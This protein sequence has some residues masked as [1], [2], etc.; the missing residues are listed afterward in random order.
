[1]NNWE[2]NMKRI[3][4]SLLLVTAIISGCG[5][6]EDVTSVDDKAFQLNTQKSETQT[7]EVK[8]DNSK[9]TATTLLSKFIKE[10]N[11]GFT[12][13]V[14]VNE[15][16]N[17]TVDSV[18]GKSYDTLLAIKQ[19][20]SITMGKDKKVKMT[21]Y[22]GHSYTYNTNFA[23]VYGFVTS[24]KAVD[25]H[26]LINKK[27]KEYTQD[28]VLEN[29]K[30]ACYAIDSA[31]EKLDARKFN[32]NLV[33]SDFSNLNFSENS[34]GYTV[35]GTVH[36]KLFGTLFNF[37][38]IYTASKLDNSD[39]SYNVT[40]VF[41]KNKELK[42]L[43]MELVK[44]TGK[45]ESTLKRISDIYIKEHTIELKNIQFHVDTADFE[46]DGKADKDFY[47]QVNKF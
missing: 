30:N 39:C 8:E 4:V 29:D 23:D 27:A 10:L 35:K 38:D 15:N 47:V 40:F 46:L 36:S 45:Y 20:G 9:V 3:L 24:N 34:D 33:I 6:T 42:S 37:E 41:D 1:M 25:S 22:I 17:V 28:F 21:G 5:K 26:S 14:V 13:D 44:G 11:T 43:S 19:K 18:K 32:T 12:A 2:F 31:N 16:V 7:K